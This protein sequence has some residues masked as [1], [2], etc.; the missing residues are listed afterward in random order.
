MIAYDLLIET[1]LPNA[2]HRER[3]LC[4]FKLSRRFVVNGIP[5]DSIFSARLVPCF[6]ILAYCLPHL[7][8]FIASLITLTFGV[9]TE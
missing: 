9:N 3:S 5:G 1:V 2:V 4:M 6:Q 7:A 8:S